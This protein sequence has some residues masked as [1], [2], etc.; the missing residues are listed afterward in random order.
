MLTKKEYG[1]LYSKKVTSLKADLRAK[2]LNKRQSFERSKSDEQTLKDRVLVNIRKD[3][4]SR[5]VSGYSAILGEIFIVELLMAL[6]ER[7]AVL[8]LPVITSKNVRMVFKKWDTRRSLEVGLHNI[9]EPGKDSDEVKPD[10][11][12][13]PLVAFDKAGNRLGMG[14]GFYDKYIN[15]ERRKRKI[16][17][18]GIGYDFQEVNRVPCASHDEKM[19]GVFTPTRFISLN[20]LGH[21]AL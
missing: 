15:E 2:L 14:A 5:C 10:I 1:S 21:M 9:S 4:T 3:L 17:V 20:N 18:Y 8:G 7:G 16:V 19:D 6:E 11:L 12:L 13:V